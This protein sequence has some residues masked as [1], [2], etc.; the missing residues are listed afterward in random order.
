ML[1]LPYYHRMCD[2]QCGLG[3]CNE[4]FFRGEREKK[5]EK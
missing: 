3:V 2:W 1:K 5:N 4:I